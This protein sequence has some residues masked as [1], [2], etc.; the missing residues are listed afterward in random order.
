MLFFLFVC[1]FFFC[2]S[3]AGLKNDDRRKRSGRWITPKNG[4]QM[5]A[6]KNGVEWRPRSL[7]YLFY[8]SWSFFFFFFHWAA[9]R[10]S[11]WRR[12]RVVFFFGTSAMMAEI[13]AARR[14]W[15]AANSGDSAAF[16]ALQRPPS[17]IS[18]AAAIFFFFSSPPRT[19][20]HLFPE[21]K[22]E[23]RRTKR[24]RAGGRFPRVFNPL[25]F[26]V[27]QQVLLV[28]YTRLFLGLTRL[29]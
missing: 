1:L 2:K 18:D 22:K 14:W 3:K 27:F 26:V 8:Y 24:V 21:T 23:K 5:A 25:G 12:F 19:A 9:H 16:G 6:F 29:A 4:R 28:I 7:L 15:P 11:S 20:S 17:F 10:L 13:A